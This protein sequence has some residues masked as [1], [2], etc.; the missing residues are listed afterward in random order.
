MP[1]LPCCYLSIM[2]PVGI[3]DPS[4]LSFAPHSCFSPSWNGMAKVTAAAFARG[5]R[6]RDHEPGECAAS[7]CS[8]LCDDMARVGLRRALVDPAVATTYHHAAKAA[9]HSGA[10]RNGVWSNVTGIRAAAW[11]DVA[12]APRIDWRD[13]QVRA[14]A[15]PPRAG[16]RTLVCGWRT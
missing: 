1:S 3:L 15:R 12:A 5:L 4:P 14:T 16:T 2:L 8:L 13:P 9:L 7:E 10:A 11:A 6:F